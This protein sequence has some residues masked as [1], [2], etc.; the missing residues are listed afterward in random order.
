MYSNQKKMTYKSARLK[1]ANQSIILGD[2]FLIKNVSKSDKFASVQ[3]INFGGFG[4]TWLVNTFQ[5]GRFLSQKIISQYPFVYKY[6][7]N[8]I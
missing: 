7:K 4:P 2:W 5:K 1:E 8:I 6:L 3:D